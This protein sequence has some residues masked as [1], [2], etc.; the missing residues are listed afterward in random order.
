[1]NQY[2]T[3]EQISKLLDIHPKTIQRYIREGKLRAVKIGKGWRVTG[4]DLSAF[5]ESKAAD[6]RP[7]ADGDNRVSAT[8]SAVVDIDVGG[9]DGAIRIINA[10]TAGLNAK[11]AEYGKS[12]MHTQFIEAE[13]KVRV[14]L[15]GTVRLIA[16]VMDAISMLT[17][18]DNEE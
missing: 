11:P 6:L 8:A 18:Q 7:L 13:N 16:A 1:M 17:E 10:L 4:H 2:Y 15:W 9:R 3:V 5:T 12:S 14:T